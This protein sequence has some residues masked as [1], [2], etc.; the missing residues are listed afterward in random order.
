MV[1]VEVKGAAPNTNYL[2]TFCANGGFNSSCNEFGAGST[3]STDAAGN[4][5]TDLQATSAP[6][7]VF[8][9]DPNGARG[10]FVSAFVVQ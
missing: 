5:S 6:S 8:F 9:V 7:E 3:F 1:H 10:G 4:G 2:L